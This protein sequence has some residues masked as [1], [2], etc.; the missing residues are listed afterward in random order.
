MRSL[1]CERLES[2]NQA[3]MHHHGGTRVLHDRP[4]Q[5]RR[6]KNSELSSTVVTVSVISVAMTTSFVCSLRSITTIFI[7]GAVRTKKPQIVFLFPTLPHIR[8]ASRL[9]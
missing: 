8:H 2:T 3:Q 5:I 9:G 6:R 1:Q 7:P 4:H